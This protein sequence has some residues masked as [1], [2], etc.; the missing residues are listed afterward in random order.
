LRLLF[1]W[2]TYLP[3]SLKRHD[4]PP[5]HLITV[6]GIGEASGKPDVA[7]LN[8]G[9]VTVAESPI[10]AVERN[11]EAIRKLIDALKIAGIDEAKIQTIGFNV[12]TIDE[13]NGKKHKQQPPQNPSVN[14]SAQTSQN[15]QHAAQQAQIAGYEA[16]NR[17]R[18]TVE[19]LTKLTNLLK[20]AVQAGVE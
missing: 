1:A 8:I 2:W 18:V 13:V 11:N 16:T 19:D 15:S 3:Y 12:V 14:E 4:N 10:D 5:A 17:I 9:V 6:R 7:I 20:E